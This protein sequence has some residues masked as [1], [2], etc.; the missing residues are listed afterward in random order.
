MEWCHCHL[1]A[2]ISETDVTAGEHSFRVVGLLRSARNN[3][4]WPEIVCFDSRHSDWSHVQTEASSLSSAELSSRFIPLL[5]RSICLPT[6][7]GTTR[8]RSTMPIYVIASGKNCGWH[9]CLL[10]Y[11]PLT[12]MWLSIQKVPHASVEIVPFRDTLMAI[13]LDLPR[14]RILLYRL[15]V[16]Q[17][18]QDQHRRDEKE[19]LVLEAS[20]GLDLVDF[21]DACI[22]H[23]W[24]CSSVCTRSSRPRLYVG[25]RLS[26]EAIFDKTHEP[27]QRHPMLVEYDGHLGSWSTVTLPKDIL[28]Q[29]KYSPR[30][31]DGGF[32]YGDG[33]HELG[34]ITMARSFD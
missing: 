8:S 28:S 33:Y 26:Q 23:S 16:E 3:F 10:K 9:T 4:K 2:E 18:E 27:Q 5:N 14:K 25:I 19:C 21:V 20:S 6:P 1:Q 32:I 31:V 12:S 24:F 15:V 29:Q 22:L 13:A 17:S 30:A 34:L 7:S 11:E